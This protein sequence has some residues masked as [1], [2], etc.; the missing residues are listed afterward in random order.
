[1]TSSLHIVGSKGPGG[2]EKFYARLVKA[3]NEAGHEV[4]AV[5]PPNSAVSRFLGGHVPQV[6]IP[7]RSVFDL[8]SRWRIGRL[9]RS[10]SPIVVQTYMGRATRLTHLPRGRGIVHVARLGGYYNL[11]GYRH[12][13][14][15]VGNTKGICQYMI[16]NGLPAERV[17]HIGNFVDLVEP[18]SQEELDRLR[19]RIGLSDNARALVSL[20]RLHPDKDYAALLEAF[21][22]LPDSIGGR[23]LHL[24]IVGHGPLRDELHAHTRRLALSERVHWAGWQTQTAA[25]YQLAD[26][27]ICPS[28]HEPLGNVILEAWANGAPVVS[29]RTFGAE[30]LVTDGHDGLL[31]PCGD[32]QALAGVLH[33]LLEGDPDVPARIA[34]NGRETLLAHH[35]RGAVVNRYLELY[36]QLAGH[37]GC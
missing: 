17:F 26:V 8:A 1:M 25:Y 11:K 6:H 2:A 28:A 24:V 27:F 13:H 30:E 32:P 20:G 12:A 9:A 10:L 3:L 31:V 19:R 15:W 35:S 37:A 33:E 5:N 18:A 14:A 36:R 4:L 34:R 29:T 22:A 23:T 16:R 21:A 7:M